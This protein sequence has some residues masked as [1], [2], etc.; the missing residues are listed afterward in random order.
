MARPGRSKTKAN[1]GVRE[2]E[3]EKLH[4]KIGRLVVEREFLPKAPGR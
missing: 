1:D 4:A 3:L 2:G